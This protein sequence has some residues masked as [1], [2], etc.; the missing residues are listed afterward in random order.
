MFATRE[1]SRATGEK[2]EPYLLVGADE[3]ISFGPF[4]FTNAE[5]PVVRAGLTYVPAAVQ[6]NSIQSSGTLDRT[7]LELTIAEGFDPAFDAEFVAYPPGCVVNL[8]VC[9]GHV[10]EN[11]DLSTTFPT[12]WAGRV[13][14]AS[15]AENATRLLCEPIA[16][17]LKRPGLRRNFQRGCPHALFDAACGADR[18][19]ASFANSV[20]TVAPAGHVYLTGALPADHTKFT[21][22]MLSW[23][24]GAGKVEF[25]TIARVLSPTQVQLRGLVTLSSG[26]VVTVM[27][28]CNHTM[29]DCRTLHNNIMNYGGAPWIPLN[30]PLSN[31]NQFF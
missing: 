21:G 11:P 4:G 23:T 8:F 3:E 9:Q 27:R 13:L 29:D 14:A 1:T 5:Q 22:G 20:A 2:V 7:Q 25:R 19:A 16:S 30:N 26:V 17:V 10:G 12:V 24:T 15:K 31:R 28:G 6:R 18:N